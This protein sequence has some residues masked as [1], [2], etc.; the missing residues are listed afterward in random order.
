MLCTLYGSLFLL[1][2]SGR[3]RRRFFC[4]ISKI[5][6]IVFGKRR[7]KCRR[8]SRATAVGTCQGEGIWLLHFIHKNRTTAEYAAYNRMQ[9]RK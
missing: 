4:G 9:R 2:R 8:H 6:H 1:T 5:Q 3:A 7:A